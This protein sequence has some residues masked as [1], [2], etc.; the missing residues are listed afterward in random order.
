[1][2]CATRAPVIG[3][4]RVRA[5]A[6]DPA[7]LRR[8]RSATHVRRTEHRAHGAARSFAGSDA[9]ATQHRSQARTAAAERERSSE[10]ASTRSEEEGKSARAHAL[11]NFHCNQTA[12]RA[13]AVAIAT[14]ASAATPNLSPA[15][16]RSMPAV[17][18]L[19][20]TR[21]DR[22]YFAAA[23]SA[24]FRLSRRRTTCPTA[25]FA[26]RIVEKLLVFFVVA[27]VDS[28]RLDDLAS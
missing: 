6:K 26:V 11:A 9:N 10:G 1:M 12:Q 7:R 27:E 18:I 2:Y 13:S 28:Q 14:L 25:S 8:S 17:A 23:G 20:A 4:V 5:A 15:I 21:T 19:R 24:G 16:G 22:V 3:I